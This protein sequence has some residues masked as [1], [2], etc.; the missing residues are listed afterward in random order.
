MNL[1]KTEMG[2]P[3]SSGEREMMK[4]DPSVDA[5]EAM[6][7]D[8]LAE[9]LRR[10]GVQVLDTDL[11]LDKPAPD[12]HPALL[13]QARLIR[14]TSRMDAAHIDHRKLVIID[15]RMGYCGSANFGAQ[16][17]FRIPFDPRHRGQGGG[18]AGAAAGAP[19]P[20]WKWHDGLVRFEGAIVQ[21][22]EAC[23][24]ERWVLD[25]GGRLRHQPACADGAPRGTTIDQA[26]VHKNQPDA[27]PNQVR[28]LF[29]AA[30][31]RPSDRSSSRTRTSTTRP[32]V[33]ALIA[34]RRRRPSLQVE[35]VVPGLKWNDN[36]FSQDAMQH[37]YGAL[38]R[39]G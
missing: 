12:G 17:L 38:V 16:Y 1:S 30:S 15:G 9:D 27:T 6:D 20:W 24:R 32:I 29:L 5:R 2:D 4:H 26:E 7:A 34:A 22:L 39:A 37:H 13:E 35:L 25:G 23:F 10:G 28:R 18:A 33:E 3:F 21:E 8:R 31:P 36:E 11:D 19:E 14:E